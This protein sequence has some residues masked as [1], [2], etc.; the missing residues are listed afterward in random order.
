[1]YQTNKMRIV[2]V[3]SLSMMGQPRRRWPNIATAFV[4]CFV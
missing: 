2:A 4:E 3:V 1:M